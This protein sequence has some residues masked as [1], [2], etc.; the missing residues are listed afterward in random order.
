MHRHR[1]ICIGGPSGAGKDTIVTA[2]LE[3]NTNY[4][5]VPRSTTRVPRPKEKEGVH[6]HFLSRGVFREKFFR[7]DIIAIDRFCG[8][9]YG[10]DVSIIQSAIESRK[11]IIG[12]FGICSVELRSRLEENITLVYIAAPLEIL[13]KRLRER[14][15]PFRNILKRINAAKKQLADEPYHF[16]HIIWNIGDR[17]DA[18]CELNQILTLNR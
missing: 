3:E 15:D 18:L 8:E 4:I 16:D 17:H 1:I 10:I 12:V 9:Y 14:G 6:Y 11:N 2:F 13:E 7:G 5:R